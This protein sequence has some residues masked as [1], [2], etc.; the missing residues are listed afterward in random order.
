MRTAEEIEKFK[1]DIL[2]KRKCTDDHIYQLFNEAV[3]Y[4]NTIREPRYQH[5]QIIEIFKLI[6]E[7]RKKLVKRKRSSC[8]LTWYFAQKTVLRI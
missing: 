2:N 5:E 3:E 8:S 4:L 1:K 7:H 6:A